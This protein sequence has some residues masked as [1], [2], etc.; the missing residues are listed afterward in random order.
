M[1]FA[2]TISVS[3]QAPHRIFAYSFN[4]EKLLGYSM[5]L[6][7]G[8]SI[9]FF[10]GPKIDIIKLTAAIKDPA[11]TAPV[12][13]ELDLYDRQ[14]KCHRVTV[15]C[16]PFSGTG[17]AHA[18][19]RI[20]IQ[21]VKK[22]SRKRLS[23]QTIFLPSLSCHQAIT[24]SAAPMS[25]TKDNVDQT[26]PESPRL[27]LP[28]LSREPVPSPYIRRP[29]PSMLFGVS[30]SAPLSMKTVIWKRIPLLPD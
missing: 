16:S 30:L 17:N 10:C 2:A 20:I 9:K 4:D 14:G 1:N 11:L 25:V 7:R 21:S 24:Q 18:L 22:S 12:T 15:S 3:R 13:A 27:A 6:R 26:P 8:R 28:V 29:A 5:E 23:D 19:C